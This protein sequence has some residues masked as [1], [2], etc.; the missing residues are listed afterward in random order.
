MDI[1]A[2]TALT[3]RQYEQALAILE[4]ERPSPAQEQ[5]FR[6]LNRAVWG[7]LFFSLLYAASFPMAGAQG[8]YPAL[9]LAAI[10]YLLTVPLF[11]LNLG[12]V[13]KLQR[14][15][16]LRRRLRISEWLLPIF[17]RRQR[18]HRLYNLITL[19]LSIVGYPVCLVGVVGL[20]LSLGDPSSDG[21]VLSIILIVF[22]LTCIFIHFIARGAERLKVITELR[23][24]LLAATPSSDGSG[25]ERVEVPVEDYDEIAGIERAQIRR[26][27]TRSV[28]RGQ[29]VASSGYVLRMSRQI[30]DMESELGE[31]VRSQVDVRVQQL[32]AEPEPPGARTEYG[33]G[34]LYIDV[35]GTGFEIAYL[36][37]HERREIRAC[38]LGPSIARGPANRGVN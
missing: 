8:A 4:R 29:R 12:L 10:C 5:R 27:R 16:T 18:T 22:G 1:P 37:D 6:L 20:A 31:E 30:R 26:D 19:A 13:R 14:A 32:L 17:R 9:L 2:T 24:G 33:T 23:S 35:P 25:S 34:L 28:A 36:V 38:S 21:L 3:Y 11:L 15:A 7:A